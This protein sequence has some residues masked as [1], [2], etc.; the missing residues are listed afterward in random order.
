MKTKKILIVED[1]QL[2]AENLRWILNKDGYNF[3]DVAMD[4]KEAKQLFKKNKYDLV[5]MDINLGD[6]SPVDGIDLIKNLLLHYT[7]LFIYVTANTD[8]KTLEK[9]R[10]TYPSGF[11]VKPFVE[12]SVYANVEMVLNKLNTEKDFFEFI[13]KKNLK[14]RVLISN[15]THI[16]S[17][18][19]YINIYFLN[20][21][22]I[23][24]RMSIAEFLEIYS[25]HFIRIHRSMLVNKIHIQGYTSMAVKVNGDKFSIGRK[26]K[27][28]FLDRIKGISFDPM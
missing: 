1:E 24:V 10:A 23:V 5:L 20:G 8:E 21:S 19:G 16:K 11:I 3:V 17:D 7:F 4:V 2:I 6:Y 12:A 18:G 25:F 26:Y 15:I 28:G 14:Q 22:E 27:E 13:N 9:V